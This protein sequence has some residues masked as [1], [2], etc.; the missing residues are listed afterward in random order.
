MSEQVATTRRSGL[1]GFYVALALVTGAGAA[2]VLTAGS[3]REPTRGIAGGYDLEGA[4]RCVGRQFDL[5]QSGRFVNLENPDATASGRLEFR[6]PELEGDVKCVSG[7]SETL[8][9]RVAGERVQGTLGDARFVAA[10]TRDP[11][12]AGSRQ[13]QTPASVAGEY[14]LVPQSL[15]LGGSIELEGE[16]DS[17]ELLTGEG[18]PRGE[19][20]YRKGKLAGHA[21]CAEGG[22][23]GITGEAVDRELRLVIQGPGAAQERLT[24]TKRR[25]FG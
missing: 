3:D 10:L 25:E 18:P 9:A 13:P 19:A 14:K 24:A 6:E 8:R 23:A 21:R 20:R 16:S 4:N 17:L 12:P 15:C 11:P 5:R 2:A 22:E 1:A 7:G